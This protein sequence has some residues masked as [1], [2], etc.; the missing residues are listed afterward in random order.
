[1][2]DSS[3]EVWIAMAEVVPTPDNHHLEGNV[4]AYV[5]VLV[6]ASS[7]EEYRRRAAA[8]LGESGFELLEVD[9]CEPFSA[10]P[11]Q[12]QSDGILELAD[13]CGPDFPVVFDTFHSFPADA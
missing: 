11:R 4:G 2:S 10:R 13:Q 1:M 12:L 8:V 5:N 3:A 9:G 6:W 7:E